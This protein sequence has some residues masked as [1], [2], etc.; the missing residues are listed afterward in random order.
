MSDVRELE[1]GESGLA[2]L[3]LSELRP[4]FV[5]R[6]ALVAK[7]D[8]QRAHGYR[9][10]ASFQDGDQDAAAV[11]GFRICESLAWGRY[12][13]VDDLVTR[14]A[15][16]GGGHADLVF[17]WVE[18]RRRGRAA[19]NCT[20]IRES[21]QSAPMRTVSISVTAYASPPITSPENSSD[22]PGDAP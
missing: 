6:E 19:R 1:G 14:A 9:L 16:R 10:A 12:L 5:S 21:G 3:A 11:A 15:L 8:A 18:R 20:W 7:V 4:H 2:V 22:M 17:A 13:Y